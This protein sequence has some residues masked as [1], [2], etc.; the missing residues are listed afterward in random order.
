MTTP[1]CISP[2][3]LGSPKFSPATYQDFQPQQAQNAK[4]PNLTE[5]QGSSPNR[6][7]PHEHPP[8]NPQ[9]HLHRLA[10]NIITNNTSAINSPTQ[11]P[12]L[13]TRLNI[14]TARKVFPRDSRPG[15]ICESGGT[16][17]MLVE[18]SAQERYQEAE[19]LQIS[20]LERN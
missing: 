19:D 1:V 8:H 11:W 13:R 18:N 5:P 15:E 6:D 9:H 17:L 20:F 10:N 4:I 2:H 16:N 12:S 14:T 7:S 3:F